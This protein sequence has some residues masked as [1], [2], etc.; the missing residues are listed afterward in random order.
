VTRRALAGALIAVA[1]TV[2]WQI[3]ATVLLVAWVGLGFYLTWWA[4]RG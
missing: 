4:T 2:G 3:L 1:A